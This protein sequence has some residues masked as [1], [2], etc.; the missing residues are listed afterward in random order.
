MKSFLKMLLASIIGGALLLFLIFIIFASLAS[1][2]APKKEIKEGSVLTLNL[3]ASLVE[4]T[5]ENPFAELTGLFAQEQVTI[6][7][8]DA[9]AGLKAAKNDSK[10]LGVMLNGGLPFGDAASIKELRD[11]LDDFKSTGKFIYGY[12]EIMSQKGLY[13]SSVAD[14][15]MVQPEGLIEFIGLNASVTYYKDALE[16]LGVEPVVLRATGNKFKSAVEPYLQ[17]EMSEPN[18]QQLSQL[19]ASVWQGYLKDLSTASKTDMEKLNQLADSFDLADPAEAAENGL[20]ELVGYQDEIDSLLAARAGVEDKD[21]IPFVKLEKYAKEYDLNGN[22][23][24]NDNRIAVVIA[25]G[26]IQSGKGSEYTIG[27]ERIAKAIKKARENEKVKA[28]VLRINSPGGSALAS[29][30]IWREVKLTQTVKPVIASMGG[31]AASGGYY[32]ACFADTIVAQ[33]NTITGSIGAFGLFFTAQELLNEKLGLNIETVSTNNYSDLGTPD[34]DIT[35][36]EKR[37]LV[38][39][40]DRVYQTFKERVAEGRGLDL[41]YVDSIGQ[42]RVYSGKDAL[43]LGLVDVLGGYE[44]ALDIA[45]NMADLG[46]DYQ[47]VEYPEPVDAVQQLLNDLN[48]GIKARAVKAQLG[49]LAPYFESIKDVSQRQGV[50]TRLEYDIVID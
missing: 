31:V 17:N 33:P 12:S 1:L 44:T 7:L 5:E 24:F 47:V 49:P 20:I 46:T 3:N 29:D 13:L 14:T 16:K 41:S 27:S 22:K 36:S 25:Q 50:Q 23:G 39:Q 34:R 32:I 15:F 30:V 10:I 19:L 4:R 26:G 9:I 11:A 43:E 6:G 18:R 42:G 28:V 2:S 21:D 40:V 48:G 45:A 37:M 38:A 8:N 35:P